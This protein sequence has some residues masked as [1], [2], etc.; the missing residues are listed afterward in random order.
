YKTKLAD[1]NG[2]DIVA[3]HKS[4]EGEY[5][6]STIAYSAR[7]IRN[8]ISF[9]HG[10]RE[11]NFSP[12]EIIPIKYISADKDVVSRADFEDMDD[13]LDTDSFG[14]LQKKLIINLLWDTGMRVSELCDMTLSNIQ[15][16]KAGMRGAKVRSRKSLRYNYVIWGSKTNELMNLYLGLRLCMDCDSDKLF[17]GKRLGK[18]LTTR[19]IQRWIRDLCEMAMIDKDITPHSFRHGKAHDMLDQGANIRDVQAILRHVKPESSFHYI[20]LSKTKYLDV[21]NKY[22]TA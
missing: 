16:L 8:F 15:E 22:L 7:I 1:I 9:W 11:V 19:T 20:Q 3:Y 6:S 10:R 5:S 17:I 2:D 12:K 14:E 13:L 4:L 21:A 18:C